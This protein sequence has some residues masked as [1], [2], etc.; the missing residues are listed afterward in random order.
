MAGDSRPYQRFKIEILPLENRAGPGEA[1]A[2]GD[3]Q[4][5][6]TLLQLHFRAGLMEGDGNAGG[7]HVSVTVDV[8]EAA[9][10][11]EFQ[12]F[13]QRIDDPDVGLMRDDTGDLL[14]LHPDA[15]TNANTDA[16]ADRNVYADLS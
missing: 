12:L 1:A 2:E 6:V 10:P 15:D 16:D 9:F 14:K 13:H 11:G 7:R 5:L 4:D 3:E 8:G